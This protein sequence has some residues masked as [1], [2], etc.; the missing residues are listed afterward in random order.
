METLIVAGAGRIGRAIA[1]LLRKGGHYQVELLDLNPPPNTDAI[2]FDVTHPQQLQA[3]IQQ[4]HARAIIACLPFYLTIPIATAA[5]RCQ[6]H[7]FDLTEDIHAMAEVADIAAN[8]ESAFVPQCGIAPGLTNV[9]AQ[10]L[11]QQFDQVETVKL[12][13]GALPIAASNALNYALT[14]SIDG[15]INEY[16]NPCLV[17]EQGEIREAQP[18]K[19]L[20]TLQ[21]DGVE[22]EAFNTSGGIGSL[23]ETYT[24]QVTTMNYKTLRYPGHCEKMRFLMQDLKLNQDRATLKRILL[25][26]LPTT[27][28]DKVMV[29]VSV[30]G[31]HQGQYT[32]KH[33]IRTFLPGTILGQRMTAI[34]RATACSACAVIDTVLT[35]SEHYHGWVRQEQLKLN[36]LLENRF[37]KLLTKDDED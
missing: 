3:Y 14:W 25:N 4:V 33:D 30:T 10:E 23:T 5:R 37:G 34:A 28:H 15:L 16:A 26:V 32:E 19:E 9:I 17:I 8:Q 24:N 7:Y 18:L 1:H 2:T 12:R 13:C 36:T 29:Y 21:I 27:H 11:I 22:Y 35:H 20:E 6:I 31:Q